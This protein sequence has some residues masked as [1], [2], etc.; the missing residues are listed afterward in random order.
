VVIIPLMEKSPTPVDMVDIPLFTRFYI[1]QLAMFN[2]QGVKVTTIFCVSNCSSLEINFI[3]PCPPF[4]VC[5]E[6]LGTTSLT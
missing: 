1:F 3:W 4:Y 2:L 5:D 6:D